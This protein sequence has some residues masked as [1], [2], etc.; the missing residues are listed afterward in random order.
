[1]A[2]GATEEKAVKINVISREKGSGTRGAFVE[3]TGVEE[4]VD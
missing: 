1:M 2:Q 3:L 4:K